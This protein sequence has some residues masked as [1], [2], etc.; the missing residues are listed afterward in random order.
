MLLRILLLLALVAST[1]CDSIAGIVGS[2]PTLAL[3]IPGHRRDSLAD[4]K[5]LAGLRIVLDGVVSESFVASDLPVAPF[6]V[7]GSGTVHVS[8]SL[9]QGSQ[10]LAQREADWELVPDARWELEVTRSDIPGGAVVDPAEI[11]RKTRNPQC[12]F[13]LLPQGVARRDRRR[14]AQLRGR[15]ALADTLEVLRRPMRA[16]LS[17]AV[18]G[19]TRGLPEAIPEEPTAPCLVKRM[20]SALHRDGSDA[21]SG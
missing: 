4:P 6:G 14:C 19:R 8:V 7:P 13:F 15:S 18:S 5:G 9:S 17:A 2:R 1:G 3:P 20:S 21:F 10:V 12:F 11:E 16:S